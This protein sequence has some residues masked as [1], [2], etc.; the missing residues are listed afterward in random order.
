MKNDWTVYGE[1]NSSHLYILMMISSIRIRHAMAQPIQSTTTRKSSLETFYDFILFLCA[2]FFSS[3]QR[4]KK[5]VRLYPEFHW[6]S[7][8]ITKTVCKFISVVHVYF[9]QRLNR[10]YAPYPFIVSIWHVLSEF[11][12]WRWINLYS[13]AF[14]SFRSFIRWAKVEIGNSG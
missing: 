6:K 13:S 7:F 10:C 9:Q 4:K 3:I 12:N 1:K 14:V 11:R 8:S 2:P 5:Y